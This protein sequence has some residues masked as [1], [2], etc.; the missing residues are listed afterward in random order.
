MKIIGII[1]ARMNASRFPGKPLFNILGI[2]MI[3]HV[4]KRA[5]LFPDWDILSLAT[6][7]NEIMEFAKNKNIPTILTSKSHNRA[8]DRVKEAVENLDINI[9]ENDIIV[10]VQGDEPMMQP[11][12]IN[13][14][15]EPLIKDQTKGCTV[16]SMPIHSEEVWKNPDTVKIIANSENKVLY[17]TRSPVPYCKDSFSK[18]IGA[19]RIFGIFA[20][21]WYYLKAFSNHEQTRLEKLESCDSNRILDMEFCQHVAP[22]HYVD[23]F[24]VDSPAD[25]KLVE[26]YMKNDP[27][28]L[29]Y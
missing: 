3:E 1:P 13:S 8:L 11:D 14:V 2:P 23:S 15:I 5:K 10:N 27:F 6:C 20:F 4:Y 17:T 24:S 18:E 9:D 25:I 12:M 19:I 16:L 21:K 22:Y 7:D 29:K 28:F 26:K